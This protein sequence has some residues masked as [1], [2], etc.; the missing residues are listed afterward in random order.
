MG[1]QDIRLSQRQDVLDA[2]WEENVPSLTRQNMVRQLSSLRLTAASGDQLVQKIR[3][4][5]E[6]EEKVLCYKILSW[7]LILA[8]VILAA[9]AI[10]YFQMCCETHTVS[11]A[12]S[13]RRCSS[14]EEVLR[15]RASTIAVP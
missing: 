15:D 5:I 14:A 10:Y 9:F 13:H 8:L 1:E 3:K 4:E 7:V 11:V 6:Q 12:D 2:F